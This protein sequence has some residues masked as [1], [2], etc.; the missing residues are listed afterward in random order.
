MS[1]ARAGEHVREFTWVEGLAFALA[2]IGIQLNS[3][4]FNQ[5]GTYFYS[6]TEGTGRIIYVPIHLVWV[7]F[8]VATIWDALTDPYVGGLS[9]KTPSEPGRWRFPR[10]SGRRRPYIFWGSILM[11]FTFVGAWYPPVAGTSYWNLAFGTF[12]LCAHFLMFT[13]TT[14]PIL[15]LGPEVARSQSARVKLGIWIG[16]GFIFGLAIANALTGELV[17]RLDPARVEESLTVESTSSS[18]ALLAGLPDDLQSQLDQEALTVGQDGTLV[19][20]GQNLAT[21]EQYFRITAIEAA[22]PADL[23]YPHSI[24]TAHPIYGTVILEGVTLGDQ[25]QEGIKARLRETLTPL[26]AREIA[27][28]GNALVFSGPILG[29]FSPEETLAV[30]EERLASPAERRPD[31]LVVAIEAA[32]AETARQALA[33][34]M[35]RLL[36]D[37]RLAFQ[38]RD[39]GTKLIVLPALLQIF[40]TEQLRTAFATVTDGAADL[41]VHHVTAVTS[42][43]GYRRVAMLYAVISLLLFQLPVWLV[44]ER[45]TPV[46]EHRLETP[47]LTAMRQAFTNRPFVCYFIGFFM[48]S[49]GFLAVQRVLAYWAEV[50][51]GGDEGMVTV[52]LIPYLIV[53]LATLP[54]MPAVARWIGAKW[55]MV[56]ALFILSSSLPAMYV[57]GVADWAQQVKIIAGGALFGYAGIGQSIIYVMITPLMGEI[58]DYDER[59]TGERREALYNGLSG[60]AWKAS[61][62]FSILI[63]TQSMSIWGNSVT[64]PLGIYLVGPIAGVC[65]LIGLVA[66]LFYP[67][68]APAEADADVLQQTG[69]RE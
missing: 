48:F 65:G 16:V 2:Y 31:G 22:I 44:R 54:L 5:W 21:I 7:I 66:M 36:V 41:S 8:V 24:D 34:G 68:L 45:F 19:F 12:M 43:E 69:S 59:E 10:I 29:A 13:I 25:E 33:E 46:T 49:A 60:V 28:E 63:A 26:V 52:L 56:A 30:A 27:I 32:K 40:T 20:T 58:I 4:T 15:A 39:D 50:G 53:A 9:D 57:I 18:D 1:R 64:E 38:P 11:M 17:T 47:W 51:L 37:E 23:S 14:V 55:M 3:E 6:P 62:A 35:A 61:M 67:K 42:P